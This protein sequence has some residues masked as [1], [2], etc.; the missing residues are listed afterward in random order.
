MLADKQYLSEDH[1]F[2]KRHS[3]LFILN[4]CRCAKHPLKSFCRLKIPTALVSSVIH[5]VKVFGIHL[6]LHAI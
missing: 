2:G 4:A 3:M 1:G 6:I 5:P